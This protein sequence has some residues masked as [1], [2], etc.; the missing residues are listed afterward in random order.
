MEPN[1]LEVIKGMRVREKTPKREKC[2]PY[3]MDRKGEL[4]EG[5]TTHSNRQERES[6]VQKG[7]SKMGFT[8]KGLVAAEK[9]T[10]T[11]TVAP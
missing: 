5:P 9:V 2:R 1:L 10:V 4:G 3:I 11:E 8:T 7:R 6:Q